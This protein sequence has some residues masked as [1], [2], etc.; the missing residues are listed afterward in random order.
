MNNEQ[1]IQI[2]LERLRRS[3]QGASDSL[4]PVDLIDLCHHLRVWREISEEDEVADIVNKESNFK[5]IKLTGTQ[6]RQLRDKDAEY[7]LTFQVNKVFAKCATMVGLMVPKEENMPF[8][9]VEDIKADMEFTY[10]GDQEGQ[11]S[12]FGGLDLYTNIKGGIK[13]TNPQPANL[14]KFIASQLFMYKAGSVQ[15]AVTVKEFIDRVANAVTDA[16]HFQKAEEEANTKK[17]TE[18]LPLLLACKVSNLDLVSFSLL[19]IAQEI[20]VAFG[21]IERYSP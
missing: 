2:Q 9:N 15:Q 21:K 7:L 13:K 1:R 6:R 18:M 14:S 12:P 11:L 19:Y 5:T 4:D 17:L 16:S 3:Y 10:G 20:L 8:S